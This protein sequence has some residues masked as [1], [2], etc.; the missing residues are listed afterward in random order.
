MNSIPQ[1]PSA[2]PA[3]APPI[4]AK[5]RVR[6]VMGMMVGAFF[7]VGG[8]IALVYLQGGMTSE[9]AEPDGLLV[10]RIGYLMLYGVVI[11]ISGVQMFR[12]GG[13][14]K[15]FGLVLFAMMIVFVN[16]PWLWKMF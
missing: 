9:A 6:A 2:T 15:P 10:V 12:N 13:I 4:S 16:L 5:T 8:A 3:D 14:S 11:V 1:T 7:T